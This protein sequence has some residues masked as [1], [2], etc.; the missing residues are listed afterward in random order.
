MKSEKAKG[1]YHPNAAPYKVMVQT[2]YGEPYMK[3]AFANKEKAE[4]YAINLSLKYK[5]AKITV[6]YRKISKTE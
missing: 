6:L 4:K 1:G 5:N 2:S 3:R